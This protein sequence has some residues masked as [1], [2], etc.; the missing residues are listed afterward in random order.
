[1]NTLQLQYMANWIERFLGPEDFEVLLNQRIPPN[2]TDRITATLQATR[3]PFGIDNV[4]VEN[5]NVKLTFDLQ[6]FPVERR[7]RLM[8]KIQSLLGWQHFQVTDIDSGVTFNCDAFLEQQQPFSD[9]RADTGTFIQ[10]FV[11]SGT[12][13][14]AS[15]DSGAIIANRVIT[16]L[17]NETLH[18]VSCAPEYNKG[19]DENLCL[20]EGATRPQVRC[21]NRVN[22]VTLTLLYTGAEI[23]NKLIEIFEGGEEGTDGINTEFVYKRIYPHAAYIQR[24]KLI[25]GHVVNTAGTLLQLTATF[26]ILGDAE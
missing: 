9:P 24:V 25:S 2:T 13:Y 26:E 4:E 14:V 21:I 1:M 8:S 19:V 20:S 17:N 11:V 6:L 15:T 16:M 23:E 12:C 3:V 22:R 5:L 18:V 10:Q 7:Y